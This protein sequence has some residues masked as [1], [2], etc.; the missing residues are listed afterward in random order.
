[1][2]L[3]IDVGN[4]NMVFGLYAGEEFV[5]SFRISTNGERTS[6]EL[7]MMI[8][9]Y[10][11]FLGRRPEDTSAVIIASVVPPVMYT[12]INAIRKYLCL[13][14]KCV[15]RDLDAGILNRYNNPR[16][17]GVDRLVN[18]VS[19]VEKYGS[20]LIIVDMG[21]AITFDAI[22]ADGAYLGGAILPGIKIAMEALFQKAAKLPR[23]DI[24]PSPHAIGKTTVESMQS[25]AVRGYVGAL[26]GIILDM[27][28]EMEADVRVIAT[29]GMGRMMAQHCSLIDT[30]DAN[31]TL[32]GLRMIYDR[33]RA[34]FKNT[35]IKRTLSDVSEEV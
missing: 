23:I 32:E 16:E 26:K 3:A 24:A 4:T 14:P 31:L 21:T 34:V 18:A 30:V 27:K 11:S 22:D 25:G 7:G 6:D 12:L 33:N 9:Q 35:R 20:P 2:L 13:Q 10:Y 15:G 29:G 28:E 8:L 5:G 17:V 1:M 19:A